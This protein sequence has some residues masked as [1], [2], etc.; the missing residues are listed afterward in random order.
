MSRVRVRGR[1]RVGVRVSGL[2][3]GGDEHTDKELA[4]EKG[5]HRDIQHK[6]QLGGLQLCRV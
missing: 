6:W 3:E 2:L 1:S 4:E 5:D